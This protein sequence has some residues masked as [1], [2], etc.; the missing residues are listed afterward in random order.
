[1]LIGTKSI[2]TQTFKNERIKEA[3]WKRL[4]KTS[5]CLAKALYDNVP[6]TPD[7]LEFHKGDTLVVL[8]QNTSNITGWWLCTLRGKQVLSDPLLNLFYHLA[9]LPIEILFYFRPSCLISKVLN[10]RERKKWRILD[11]NYEISV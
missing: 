6:D 9:S 1:M 11:G 3:V 4:K 7:E 5:Y 2:P 8:E 10:W